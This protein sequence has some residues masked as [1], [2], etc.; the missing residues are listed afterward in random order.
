MFARIEAFIDK[1]FD[2]TD[3]TFDFDLEIRQPL[4][5]NIEVFS[6][7]KE[8]WKIPSRSPDQFYKKNKEWEDNRASK[9]ESMWKAIDI[10]LREESSITRKVLKLPKDYISP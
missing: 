7:P 1:D 2:E 5:S 3:A 10:K 8:K 4:I 9:L 6:P